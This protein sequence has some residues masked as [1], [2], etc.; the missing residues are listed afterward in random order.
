MHAFERDSRAVLFQSTR[1]VKGATPLVAPFAGDHV[2]Q[3][4]RPVKGATPRGFA[5]MV[6]YVESTYGVTVV[7]IHAPREGRDMGGRGG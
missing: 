5:S 7:S 6:A 2:F 1:P 4:T 3:S